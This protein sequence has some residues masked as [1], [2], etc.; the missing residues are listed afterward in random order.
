MVNLHVIIMSSIFYP[1]K[2][3]IK[4]SINIVQLV[5]NCYISK[6]SFYVYY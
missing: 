3:V 5:I 1:M 6:L 4:H 2:K